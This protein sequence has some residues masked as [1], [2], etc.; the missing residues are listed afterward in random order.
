LLREPFEGGDFDDG[1]VE[2]H[3]GDGFT[4]RRGDAEVGRLLTMRWRPSLR[5]AAPKLMS[6]PSGRFIRRRGFSRGGA[7]VFSGDEL[8]NINRNRFRGDFF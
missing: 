5:V 6:S 1:F 4:R 3:G 7:E 2:A 8:I